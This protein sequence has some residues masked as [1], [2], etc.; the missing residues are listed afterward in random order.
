ME[1][2]GSLMTG[3]C[4]TASQAVRPPLR[5]RFSIVVMALAV[6]GLLLPVAGITGAMDVAASTRSAQTLLAA[7]RSANSKVATYQESAARSATGATGPPSAPELPWRQGPGREDQQGQG[8]LQV[9]RSSRVI[10]WAI[11]PTPRQGEGLHRRQTWRD[12]T[13]NTWASRLPSGAR[14]FEKSWSAVGTHR[15]PIVTLGTAKHPTV[16][17][18]AFLV[19]RRCHDRDR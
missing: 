17:I 5:N 18:D 12:K 14:L 15:N 11:G 13:V 10:G 7:S 2:A 9:H 6:V 16:A 3:A 8:H 19:R 4:R 1:S